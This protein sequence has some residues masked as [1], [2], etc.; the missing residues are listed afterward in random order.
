MIALS[1][2]VKWHWWKHK[3]KQESYQSPHPHG[4][5]WCDSCL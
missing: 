1:H 2:K 5:N 3:R 4:F